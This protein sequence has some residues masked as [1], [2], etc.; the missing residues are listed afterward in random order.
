MQDPVD[1]HWL[2]DTIISSYSSCNSLKNQEVFLKKL[3]FSSK[4]TTS[5]PNL[6][7][8]IGQP[9]PSHL[10]GT[11]SYSHPTCELQNYQ[12]LGNVVLIGTYDTTLHIIV[13]IQ[14]ATSLRLREN[15]TEEQS[16]QAPEER[17]KQ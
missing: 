3:P 15:E 8:A 1:I 5:V 2:Y 14:Y 4:N 13:S 11:L 12:V 9:T 7:V 10:V 6:N 16:C 17:P